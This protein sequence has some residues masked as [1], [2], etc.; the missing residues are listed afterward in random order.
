MA[1]TKRLGLPLLAP[2]QSQKH[3]TVNESLA[4]LDALVNMSLNSVNAVTPPAS[5]EEGDV[6]GVGAG[7]TDAWTGEDGRL[8]VFLNGG[9]AF[10]DPAPGWQAWSDTDGA[11]VAYDGSIWQPGAGSFSANGAGFVHRTIE[12][13]HDIG[14]GSTSVVSAIFPAGAIAYGVTAR[15]LVDI[16]GAA[17]IELGVSGSTDRYGSGIGVVAGAWAR[18]VTGTPLTYYS[19]T[20]LLVSATGGSFDG[21]GRIRIAAHVAEL[22]LPNS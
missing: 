2:A 16:G 10:L 11:R 3:V 15:V 1:D 9:W 21:T 12:I 13:D 22:T 17:S 4:R 7:A 19:A 8:A 5:P 6:H 18:G 20:D 14:V